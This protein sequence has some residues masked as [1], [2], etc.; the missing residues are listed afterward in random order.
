MDSLKLERR[1]F[2][3]RC[4]SWAGGACPAVELRPVIAEGLAWFL[5]DKKVV[6]PEVLVPCR[7]A[8][9]CR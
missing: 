6:D 5:I 8:I 1:F 7:H 3:G 4:V 9:N 2:E